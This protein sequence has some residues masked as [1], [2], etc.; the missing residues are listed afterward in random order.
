LGVHLICSFCP[1]F[2]SYPSQAINKSLTALGKVVMILSQEGEG[3]GQGQGG[4]PQHV[5]F[6]DTKLTRILKDSLIVSAVGLHW[7]PVDMY[8]ANS[9]VNDDQTKGL[10]ASAASLLVMTCAHS[11]F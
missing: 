10:A 1:S 3:A 11:A 9:M 8:M 2:L 7:V 5:P 4:K 6:R